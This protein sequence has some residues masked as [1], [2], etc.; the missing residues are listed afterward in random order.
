MLMMVIA[1]WS[2]I[3]TLLLMSSLLWYSGPRV[4]S[5]PF[6]IILLYGS[7]LSSSCAASR[8]A[9]NFAC[10]LEVRIITPSLWTPACPRMTPAWHEIRLSSLSLSY[11]VY[12]WGSFLENFIDSDCQV[13]MRGQAWICI[14]D[15]PS[16]LLSRLLYLLV[17]HP[18]VVGP[19][20]VLS[21]FL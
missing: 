15:K 18:K 10:A 7:R 17:V 3:S 20:I 12:L 11:W 5:I 4:V 8:A 2:L 19:E 13:V 6:G 14:K 9:V 1:R 16:V 21:V